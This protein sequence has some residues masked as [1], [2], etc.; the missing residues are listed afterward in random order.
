MIFP[1]W[2]FWQYSLTGFACGVVWNVCEITGL[3]CPYPHWCFGKIMG[4]KGKR[5]HP[6]EANKAL[7]SK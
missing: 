5:V 6:E 1:L 3:N 2:K 7:Q 4:S